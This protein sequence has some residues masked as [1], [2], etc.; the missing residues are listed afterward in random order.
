MNI[1][2]Q[3]HRVEQNDRKFACKFGAWS[4]PTGDTTLKKTRRSTL[5]RG[6]CGNELIEAV[7]C[8]TLLH[9]TALGTL[10]GG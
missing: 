7:V 6:W 2:N 4:R 8:I 1:V 5:P 3:G 10:I 9:E